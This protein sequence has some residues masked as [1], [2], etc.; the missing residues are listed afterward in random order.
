MVKGQQLRCQSRMSTFWRQNVKCIF[1]LY[2]H[3]CSLPLYYSTPLQVRSLEELK[4]R[5]PLPEET[6]IQFLTW[7]MNEEKLLQPEVL[8]KAFFKSI[9]NHFSFLT[10]LLQRNSFFVDLF[11]HQDLT[12]PF[13]ILRNKQA[14][15]ETEDPFFFNS[16]S[17][18]P[19]L[20]DPQLQPRYGDTPESSLRVT[21]GS[22]LY[23]HGLQSSFT[24]TPKNTKICM[25]LI[26]EGF[27][28]YALTVA[29]PTT[30]P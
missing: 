4:T 27:T 12:S 23:N 2:S 11:P 29:M 18:D 5:L 10:Y 28:L 24:G 25:L 21:V 3:L 15:C 17:L 6:Q 13:C 1:P 30:L 14:H 7:T 20:I 16:I 9:S 19:S 22:W 8:G 26:P